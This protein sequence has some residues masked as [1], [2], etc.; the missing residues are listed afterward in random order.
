MPARSC[1]S[2]GCYTLN[3]WLS[4]ADPSEHSI[5]LIALGY[6]ADI[7]G[8]LRM[9]TPG[10]NRLASGMLPPPTQSAFKAANFQSLRFGLLE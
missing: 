2:T 3:V 10:S 8:M 7:Q 4:G 6:I 9:T 5:R 1:F